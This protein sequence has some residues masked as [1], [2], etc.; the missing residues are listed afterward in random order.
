MQK[1]ARI[2]ET[3]TEVS[4]AEGGLLFILVRFN[5]VNTKNLEFYKVRLYWILIFP[6][7]VANTRSMLSR[8]NK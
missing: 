6:F 5:S 4:G 3:S 2:A 8:E 1:S 7:N